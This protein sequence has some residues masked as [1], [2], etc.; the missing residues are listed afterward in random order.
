MVSEENVQE[1]NEQNNE[2]T[3]TILA[4]VGGLGIT[5]MLVAAGIGVVWENA[6]SGLIGLIVLIGAGLLVAAIG[7][8]VI[9][10]RP[11]EHID[12]INQPMYHGHHHDDDDHHNEPDTAH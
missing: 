5:M 8:W 11:H 2:N 1:N 12:D 7:G 10:V 4:M 9:V 6:D 3:L